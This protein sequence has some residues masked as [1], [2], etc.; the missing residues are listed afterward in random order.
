M[1]ETILEF[2]LFL[3]EDISRCHKDTINQ[4]LVYLIISFPVIGITG[5]SRAY[6]P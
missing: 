4:L 5:I 3:E 1:I 6:A 2:Y